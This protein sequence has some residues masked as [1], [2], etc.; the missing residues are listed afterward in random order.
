MAASLLA[1]FSAIAVVLLIP[2]IWTAALPKAQ[3]VNSLTAPPPPPASPPPAKTAVVRRSPRRPANVYSARAPQVLREIPQRVA[4]MTEDAS[5]PLS[6]ALISLSGAALSGDLQRHPGRNRCRGAA[7]STPAPPAVPKP[8]AKPVPE[9]PL[10]V[11]GQVQN[12]KL[13]K[14]PAP[15]Y[16]AIARTARIQ[17]TVI[18][19]AIIGK[20]GTVRD[21]TVIGTA[22]PLLVAAAK[23]A[24]R[25]WIYQPTFLNRQP[26]EVMTEI[27]VT[28]TLQ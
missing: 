18:L 9:K 5:L 13:I 15:V 17:G 22:S 26:V 24:V 10:T 1:E 4:A 6:D 19:Q 28:F 20:D 11:G 2:L 23:E 25:Q 8:E 16:P 27:T 12:A 3:F 14:H 21:L 7:T